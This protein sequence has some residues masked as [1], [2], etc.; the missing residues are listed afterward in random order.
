MANKVIKALEES[1]RIDTLST[2]NPRSQP[3]VQ[4]YC[5][6]HGGRHRGT[7]AI[8]SQCISRVIKVSPA[9]TVETIA[10][11]FRFTASI[12]RNQKRSEHVSCVQYLTHETEKQALGNI[13]YDD[14]ELR[15]ILTFVHQLVERKEM[16]ALQA[17]A[18]WTRPVPATKSYSKI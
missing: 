16:R 3:R 14:S 7:L 17:R 5:N 15:R 13:T 11:W 1:I 12:Y 6:K 9:Q 2:M 18:F 4:A 10:K 8:R